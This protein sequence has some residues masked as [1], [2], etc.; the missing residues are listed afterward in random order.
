[1][2]EARVA[3]VIKP[4]TGIMK[5]RNQWQAVMLLWPW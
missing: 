2:N 4:N 3:N 1:M 5:V